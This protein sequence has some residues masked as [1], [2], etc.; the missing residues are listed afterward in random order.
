MAV[1]PPVLVPVPDP[2]RVRVPVPVPVSEPVRELVPVRVLVPNMVTVPVPVVVREPVPV[3]VPAPVPVPDPVPVAV[4]VPV[5][6][7]P[8]VSLE[9]L[10]PIAKPTP[11]TDSANNKPR[12]RAEIMGTSKRRITLTFANVRVDI[13]SKRLMGLPTGGP[14]PQVID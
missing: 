14:E 3:P 8:L 12:I 2:F 4:P 9:L 6:V 5:S 7:L 10:H 13:A 11:S 1:D